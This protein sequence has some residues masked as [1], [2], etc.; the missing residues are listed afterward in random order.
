[1]TTRQYIY[2]LITTDTILNALGITDD[3]TFLSDTVDTEQIRPLCIL[4][5]GSVTP[6]LTATREGA[7]VSRFPISQRILTVWV[8]V[9]LNEGNFDRI[10]QSLKR[11]RDILTNVAGV[12]VGE[13]GSWLSA[14]NWEGDSDDIRDDEQR[15]LTRNAQFRLT[16]SAI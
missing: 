16:G 9:A 3:S 12:N 15:T 1:M 2:N 6:G 11:L 5:W 4:R 13:V 10:D 14:I 7:G 8:H